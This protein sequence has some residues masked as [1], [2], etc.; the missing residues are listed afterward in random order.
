MFLFSFSLEIGEML[1]ILY[2]LLQRTIDR[3]FKLHS[4]C[5][6][7]CTVVIKHNS[8]FADI[9]LSVCLDCIQW[10]LVKLFHFLLPDVGS[11]CRRISCT[12]NTGGKTSGLP[13]KLEKYLLFAGWEVR[14]VKNCGRVQ[15]QCCPRPRAKFSRLTWKVLTKRTDPEPADNIFIL[16]YKRVCLRNWLTRRPQTTRKKRTSD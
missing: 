7:S 13:L 1:V 14:I 11:S 4:S 8:V 16:A 3:K 5:L 2:F 9:Y 10:K 15:W 6:I 12:L